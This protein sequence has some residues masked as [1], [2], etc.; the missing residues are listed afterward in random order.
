MLN[1]TS[2]RKTIYSRQGIIYKIAT[3]ADDEALR[4]ILQNT[5]MDGWI[6]VT[7]ER[8]PSFFAST[9]LFGETIAVIAHL[10]N[11]PKQ[12]VG[13]YLL[14]RMPVHV[15]GLPEKLGYLGGLRVL[16]HHR[17][18]IRALIGGYESIDPLLNDL[19]TPSYWFTSIAK[20]NAAARR[21]L[22]AGI[23]YLPIYRPIS[24][25]RTLFFSTRKGKNRGLLKPL[26]KNE[27]ADIV[28]FYNRQAVNYQ[29]SPVLSETWLSSLSESTALTF[30]DIFILKQHDEILGCML[31]WD[32]R[33]FKQTVVKGYNPPYD[34]IRPMYNV[35]A[36]STG[37][38]MLPKAGEPLKQVYLA[39]F[40]LDVSVHHL[41]VDILRE[42]LFLSARKNAE[43][44]TLGLSI[45]N[46]LLK[47]I[48]AELTAQAYDTLIETVAW[49]EQD[50]TVLDSRPVQPEVALL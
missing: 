7:F 34:T 23:K 42:A 26:K 3:L 15:N 17:H 19:R 2:H 47:R 43:S 31:I 5:P 38:L 24:E 41:A 16:K 18:K 33:Q 27:T 45:D 36:R 32:Q 13:M 1:E 21:I 39:F 14:T 50:F 44:A 25:M 22:E 9:Q 10:E 28:K 37:K 4:F 20:E 6:R 8:E 46:P 11:D 35:Y 49:H 30:D 12:L 48:Q 29:F 40:A